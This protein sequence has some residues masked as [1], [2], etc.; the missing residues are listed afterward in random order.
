MNLVS[1][2]PAFVQYSRA[3]DYY[4]FGCF[5]EAET[6]LTAAIRLM[7]A[8]PTP[9]LRE[10]ELLDLA[11]DALA[12]SRAAIILKKGEKS[13]AIAQII[14]VV[15]HTE[16]LIKLRAIV[17]IVPLLDDQSPHWPLLEREIDVLA[18]RGYWQAEKVISQRRLATGN[19]AAAIAHLEERLGAAENVHDSYA[20]AILLADAWRAAGR[21]LEAWLLIRRIE[22]DAGTEVIDFELRVE[23]IRVAAAVAAARAAGGDVGAAR[24]KATYDSALREIQPQ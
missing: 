11:T 2:A 1:G 19:A 9:T 16:S 6:E 14:G 8:A 18:R 20:A 17:A 5:D 22:R 15:G 21:T 4:D 13:A 12:L 10:K 23:F 7:T 3:V 24:A